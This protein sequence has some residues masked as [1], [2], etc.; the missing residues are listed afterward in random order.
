MTTPTGGMPPPIDDELLSA[1]LDGR[2]SPAERATVDAALAADPAAR[3]R[4]TDLRA[5]VALLHGLPQPAPRR[6]F[7]LTPQQGAAIRPARAS[8]ITRLFPAVSAASAVAAVLC[9]ALVAGDLATGGFSTKRQGTTTITRV[10]VA[11]VPAATTAGVVARTTAS[12]TS[13]PET[14]ISRAPAA[15]ASAAASVASSAQ[16]PGAPA[17]GAA[18]IAPTAAGGIVALPPFT[19]TIGSFAA[20]TIAFSATPTIVVNAPPPPPAARAAP[21]AGATVTTE[22]HHL[23]IALV[24]VGEILLALLAIAGIALATL[25]WR[26]RAQRT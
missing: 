17:I 10:N 26:G 8:W 11:A 18:A 13:V 6:T 9:I 21:S 7:I 19:P 24:R 22:T 16:R 3:A 1:W 20:S 15:N 23:P 4:A 14:T 12:G 2:V 5:T 25:G